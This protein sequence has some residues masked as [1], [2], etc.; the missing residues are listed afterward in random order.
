MISRYVSSFEEIFPGYKNLLPWQI[1]S[2]INEI[3]ENKIKAL[4]ENY[5]IENNIAIHKTAKIDATV[6][7]HGPTIICAE[8]YIGSYSLLRGGIYIGAGSKVGAHCEIKSCFM[9]N[10]SATAHFNFVGDSIIGSYVNIEV[11]VVF[12]NHYNERKNKKIFV[13]MDDKIIKT[14]TEKFGAVAGDGTKIGANA[15][16]SP[17]T[18]LMKKSVVK[19]LGLVEQAV[20]QQ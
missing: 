5:T 1:I 16:L 9:F 14:G 3:I 8:A 11:G 12:A 18:L 10:N 19:R 15:V 4:N 20:S 2:L 13:L 6:I 7:I 17:G